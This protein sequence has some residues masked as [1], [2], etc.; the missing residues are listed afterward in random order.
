M[1]ARRGGGGAGGPRGA[2][3]MDEGFGGC[4]WLIFVMFR[5]VGEFVV[6]L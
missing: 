4:R 2:E 6:R 5:G 3:V 1:V